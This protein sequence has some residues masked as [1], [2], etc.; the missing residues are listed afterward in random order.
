LIGLNILVSCAGIA[1]AYVKFRHY[2]LRKLPLLG[3]IIEHKFYVDELY[4]VLFVRSISK[5]SERLA[6]GVDINTVDALVMGLSRGFIRLGRFVSIMQNANVR[7]YA[8][9]MMLGVSAMA[10]YLI[11]IVR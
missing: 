1:L 9:I 7:L 2:D 6:V 4:D 3:G 11:A 10:L 5:L 8:A